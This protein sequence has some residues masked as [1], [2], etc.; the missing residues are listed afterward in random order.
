MNGCRV[1]LWNRLEKEVKLSTNIIQ[2][3]KGYKNKFLH[4]IGMSVGDFECDISNT[5]CTGIGDFWCFV[6]FF[7][8]VCCCY[9]NNLV[10]IHKLR[11]PPTPFRTQTLHLFYKLL[12]GTERGDPKA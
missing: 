3:K 10:G 11:L 12:R 4:G 8:F 2:F 6:F 7:V 5:D 9:V 1:N